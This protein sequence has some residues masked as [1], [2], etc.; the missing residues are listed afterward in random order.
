[1]GRPKGVIWRQHDLYM[2]SN[3]T[4]DPPVADMAHVAQRVQAAESRPVGLPAAPLMHGTGFVFAATVLNR[5]GMVVTLPEQ[6]F[7]AGRLLDAIGND[8]VTDLCIV[9]D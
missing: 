7:D 1:T 3:V 9:G 4:A 6:R 2:A 8:R 5:G